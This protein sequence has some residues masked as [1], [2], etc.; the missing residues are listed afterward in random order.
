MNLISFSTPLFSVL[1]AQE[2]IIVSYSE[3]RPWCHFLGQNYPQDG[4]L[5]IFIFVAK[6]KN[7]NNGI[8]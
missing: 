8:I 7:K 2:M 1:S 3:T 4:G 6:K 5:L